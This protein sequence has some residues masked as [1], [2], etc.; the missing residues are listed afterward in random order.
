MCAGEQLLIPEISLLYY[1]YLRETEKEKK[2]R[3]FTRMKLI[4]KDEKY[5]ENSEKGDFRFSLAHCFASIRWFGGKE[6]N[7]NR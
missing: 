1:T 5:G 4:R 2:T 6:E 3:I 7:K